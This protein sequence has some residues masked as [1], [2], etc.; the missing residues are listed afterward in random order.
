[1]TTIYTIIQLILLSVG[2]LLIAAYSLT[3]VN[4]NTKKQLSINQQLYL[5]SIGIIIHESSHA[6]MAFIFG[7][8]IDEVKLI[9]RPH[10]EIGD[11]SLGFVRYY[12]PSNLRGKIGGAMT[13]IAPIIGCSIA[14]IGLFSLLLPQ[15]F[16]LLVE[17]VTNQQF[18]ASLFSKLLTSLFQNWSLHLILWL[19]ITISITVGG[20]DLSSADRTGF[21]LGFS[22]LAFLNV[23][24]Y[25]VFSLFNQQSL[26]MT[27]LLTITGPI[28]FVTI[29][30]LFLLLV[31]NLIVKSL[32]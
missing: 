10:P 29:L 12:S 25:Y 3:A 2:P 22:L 17:M 5:G 13:G 21:G 4:N 30:M 24:L 28:I 8:R 26:I 15:S 32:K 7:F 20:F 14:I 9:K 23:I 27:L 1:M 18:T 19:A 11:N 16:N 31:T 6:I